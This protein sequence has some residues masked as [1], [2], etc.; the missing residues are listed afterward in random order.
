MDSRPRELR[1]QSLVRGTN[2]TLREA[3]PGEKDYYDRAVTGLETAHLCQSWQ[4]GELKARQGWEPL[5]LVVETA[6]R[7]PAGALTLLQ[8]R[9][10]GL[11][12]LYSPRGPVLDYTAP[13]VAGFVTRAVRRWGTAAGAVFWKI[14]PEVT[15][16]PAARLLEQLGFRRVPPH[17]PFLGVQPRSVWRLRTAPAPELGDLTKGAR[18]Q[19]R[20]AKKHGVEVRL[21]GAAAL[22]H[23]HRLLVA[24]GGRSRFGIRALDYYLDLWNTLFPGCALFM[25]Y[26]EGEPAAGGL[27]VPF[28][29]GV[30][31]LYAASADDQRQTGAS[32]LLAW[33]M[34][35][36]YAGQGY[37]FYDLGGIEPA[38]GERPDPQYGLHYF[39]SRFGGARLDFI[40]EFDLVFQP[41]AYALWR[42]WQA[43]QS[44]ARRPV[45][46]LKRAAAHRLPRHRVETDGD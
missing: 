30:Y 4:W 33:H 24:T 37:E 19:I 26:H 44:A 40:G 16:P 8:R 35:S 29:R 7:E 20:L 45:R 36:H 12:V 6:R 11:G 23:F 25:A 10:A 34:I 9:K 27:A 39:K 21:E 1:A 43:A 2:L 22:T 28:G 46:A 14:D 32:Y 17:G 5:R 38:A 13:D 18:R 15:D 41:A 31:D 42:Q 3:G